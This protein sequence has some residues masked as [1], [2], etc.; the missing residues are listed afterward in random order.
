[1]CINA[2][3]T[4]RDAKHL[5]VADETKYVSKVEKSYKVFCFFRLYLKNT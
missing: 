3:R 5:R 4:Q 2:L 1:M